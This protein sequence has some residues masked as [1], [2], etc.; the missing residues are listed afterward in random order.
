M[1][2]RENMNQFQAVEDMVVPEIVPAFFG[3]GD[4]K[5][6]CTC[7]GGS[8]SMNSHASRWSMSFL[9]IALWS[10]CPLFLLVIRPMTGQPNK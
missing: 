7:Q 2:C 8:P 6:L 9:R 5:N 10:V 3:I 4:G 1:I